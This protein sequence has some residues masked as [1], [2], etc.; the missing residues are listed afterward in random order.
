MLFTVTVCGLWVRDRPQKLFCVNCVERPVPSHSVATVLR[1]RINCTSLVLMSQVVISR[2]TLVV[3]SLVLSVL[4]ASVF[5]CTRSPWQNS[6][7]LS[8]LSAVLQG[9]M[10]DIS[11]SSDNLGI[12]SFAVQSGSPYPSNSTTLLCC[13]RVDSPAIFEESHPN[14]GCACF[15]SN[16]PDCRVSATAVFQMWSSMPHGDGLVFE[17]E[18]DVMSAISPVSSSCDPHWSDELV[19]RW[20]SRQIWTSV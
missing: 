3:V 14:G 8:R 11:A 16:R 17:S 5:L 1:V 18:V 7:L 6:C 12:N 2:C 9:N 4:A 13:S 10:V 19:L 15:F 20:F